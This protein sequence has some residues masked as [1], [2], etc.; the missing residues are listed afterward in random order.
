AS[1]LNQR[2]VVLVS[3]F[4][5]AGWEGA[6][7]AQLPGGAT[8]RP[9]AISD[10]ATSNTLVT[11]VTLRRQRIAGRERVTPIAH[12]ANRGDQAA[13]LD[14]TF[15]ADGRAMQTVRAEV[16]AGGTS[17][18]ELQPITLDNRPVRATVRA[19]TD[20]LPIDNVFHFVLEPSPGLRVVVVEPQ[21]RDASLYL[22]RALELGQDPP[23]NV[24]VTR[25]LPSAADLSRADVVVLN[26]VLPSDGEAGRRLVQWVK[27]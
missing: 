25:S 17:N 1:Q 27:D 13:S 23:F 5:R 9:V 14:V 3:D 15:E 4:Q 18:V 19:G 16:P 8:L 6:T 2:E 26:D 21:G 22:R 12:L 11:H 24:T 7:G 10:D 20:A